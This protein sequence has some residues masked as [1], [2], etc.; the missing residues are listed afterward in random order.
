MRIQEGS[1]YIDGEGAVCGPLTR[2][3][4]YVGGYPFICPAGVTYSEKGKYAIGAP[5]CLDLVSPVYDSTPEDW[6]EIIG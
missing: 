4:G 1:S 6:E 5:S 3:A 2:R